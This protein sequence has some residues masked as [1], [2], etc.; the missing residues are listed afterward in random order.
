MVGN[1][2]TDKENVQ[3]STTSQKQILNMNP[4]GEDCIELKQWEPD[5]G[6]GMHYHS[7]ILAIPILT[8]NILKSLGARQAINGEQSWRLGIVQIFDLTMRM[9]IGNSVFP[10]QIENFH[11]GALL[12]RQPQGTGQLILPQHLLREMFSEQ[13]KDV[14]WNTRMRVTQNVAGFHLCLNLTNMFQ[15]PFLWV[16][17][18]LQLQCFAVPKA[19]M[20]IGSQR[21][22][23]YA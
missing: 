23:V 8:H 18:E 10:W 12:T 15:Q 9:K 11:L 5:D 16:R 7:S 22:A 6:P 19:S 14:Q 21:L 20:H 4:L 1:D 2:Q 13:M 3:I 17:L